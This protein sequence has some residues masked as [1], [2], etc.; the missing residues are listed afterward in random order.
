M[1]VL[2]GN[3]RVVDALIRAGMAD[4][5]TSAVRASVSVESAHDLANLAPW[6]GVL[7]ALATTAALWRGRHVTTRVA[8]AAA[9]LSVVFPPW[10]APGGGVVVLVVARCTAFHALSRTGS[11]RRPA[12]RR[13]PDRHAEA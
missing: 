9:A 12:S 6:L 11:S 3:V 8:I 13:P 1:L 7:A 5:P 10:I 4:T 2:V